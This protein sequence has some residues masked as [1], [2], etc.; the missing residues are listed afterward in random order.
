MLLVCDIERASTYSAGVSKLVLLASQDLAQD[1]A[2]DLAGTCLG[3]I[4]HNVY[5]LGCSERS[6][7]LP[8]LQDEILAKLVVD[9]V[10]ILDRDKGVDSLTSKFI[11]H[12]DDGGFSDCGVLNEGSLD[13]SG[14]QTVTRHVDDVVDTAADPVVTL[15]VTGCSITSEL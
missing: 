14:G 9:L 6:D 13:F 3:K 8:D 10:A 15:V 12:T 7:T 2:H 11:G 4:W 1:T 5:R